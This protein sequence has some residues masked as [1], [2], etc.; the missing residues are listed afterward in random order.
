[1]NNKFFKPKITKDTIN[2]RSRIR[3]QDSNFYQTLKII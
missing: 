2:L 3:I 1:M